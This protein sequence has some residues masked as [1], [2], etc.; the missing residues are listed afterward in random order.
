MVNKDQHTRAKDV[1]PNIHRTQ[2]AEITPGSDA[3]V[4]FAAA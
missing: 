4:Q 3:M 1:S 2:A